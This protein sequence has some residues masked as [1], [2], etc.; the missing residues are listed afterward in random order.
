MGSEFFV[1]PRPL[2]L[3]PDIDVPQLAGKS[4]KFRFKIYSPSI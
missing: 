3:P 2:S 1:R 4:V